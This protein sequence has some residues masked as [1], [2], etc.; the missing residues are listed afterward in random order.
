VCCASGHQTGSMMDLTPL[1]RT[2]ADT[3][4]LNGSRCASCG[5]CAFPSRMVCASCHGRE[6]NSVV[7]AGLGQ[8]RCATQVSTPPAGFET[9]ITVGVVELAEG[10][11]LFALL[12]DGVGAGDAVQAVPT[13]VKDGAAGFTFRR[14]A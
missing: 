6:Q 1:F 12:A 5:T 8:V 10:P 9:P 7:L 2:E 11:S 13:P 14:A 3:A 4:Q